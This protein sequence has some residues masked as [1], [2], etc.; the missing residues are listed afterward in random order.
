MRLPQLGSDGRRRARAVSGFFVVAGLAAAWRIDDLLHAFHGPTAPS[1][2]MGTL[3]G[4]DTDRAIAVM[5]GWD[6]VPR[7]D[8]ASAELLGILYVVADCVV[9]VA[10]GCLLWLVARD[11]RRAVGDATDLALDRAFVVVRTAV[12]A[13]AAADLAENLVLATLAASVDGMRPP[14]DPDRDVFALLHVLTAAKWLALALVVIA[15]LAAALTA[16]TRRP[17][18]VHTG[19][20]LVALRFQVVVVALFAFAMFGPVVGAQAA[21]AMQRWIDYGDNAV[22]FATGILFTLW[23]SGIVLAVSNRVLAQDEAPPTA[24]LGSR[25]LLWSGGVLL[26]CGAVADRTIEHFRGLW[27]LGA[28][29]LALGLVA[30]VRPPRREDGSEPAVDP[31]KT[32]GT[33]EGLVLPLVLAAIPVAAL[34]L[35]LQRLAVGEGLYALRLEMAILGVAGLLLQFLAWLMVAHDPGFGRRVSRVAAWLE[36]PAGLGAS[37]VAS[38]LLAIRIWTDPWGISAALGTVSIFAAFCVAAS[39]AGFL[40]VQP[41][42]ARAPVPV[43]ARLG[44]RRQPVLLVLVL[45]LVLSSALGPGGYHDARTDLATQGGAPRLTLDG[46]WRD[47][48][49]RNPAARPEDDGGRRAIPMVFVAASGGGIRAAY[50]TAS[51]LAKTI[52]AAGGAD[53]LFVLSGASGGSVGSAFYATHLRTGRSGPAWPAETL[54]D[55]D[56]VA[57]TWSWMLY[58]DLPQAFLH[59]DL[60]PD[61]AEVLERSWEQGWSNTRDASVGRIAR[62]WREGPPSSGDLAD[63]F[64]TTS[65]GRPLLLLNATSVR[66]GC[67]LNVSV[68]DADVGRDRTVEQC[69]ALRGFELGSAPEP[70]ESPLAGTEDLVDL[71]CDQQDLR[72]S[73]AAHLS[74]RFPYVSPSGRVPRCGH[75]DRGSYAV[76]GGYF[77]NTGASAIVELWR[78]LEDRVEAFNRTSRFA[79]VVPVLLQLDNSYETAVPPGPVKAPGEL[80]VPP[81]TAAAVLGIGPGRES[82]AKQAAALAFG[83]RRFAPVQRYARLYPRAHPGTSA[84]LGWTLSETS[85]EDLDKQIDGSFNKAARATISSWFAEDLRCL[86]AG[87]G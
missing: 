17:G 10:L 33:S 1:G 29:L 24:P 21:D 3:A 78:A 83:R 7:D 28:V 52:D 49:A 70:L 53:R 34:G 54:G 48:R 41:E 45:W 76:D 79:C 51:S 23:L 26:V 69:L 6:G 55:E 35:A 16:L 56:H 63:G 75:E 58:G 9:A 77:D 36:S 61:R 86:P 27:P 65:P 31:P 85:M 25:P 40:L 19:R 74:S 22:A 50:W 39:L 68:L 11:A 13:G 14:P 67:R 72:I 18:A 64:R 8:F 32:T 42:Q 20:R 71:L 87:G 73:T 66:E 5:G 4:F 44:A 84:P 43:L 30:L 57:P 80:T 81:R 15:L 82:S 59:V 38:L 12:V 37:A 62:L 2:G 60:G 47:W 46:A